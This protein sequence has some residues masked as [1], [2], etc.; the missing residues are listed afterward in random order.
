MVSCSYLKMKKIMYII[1][2]LGRNILIKYSHYCSF[3]KNNSVS[4][5][6]LNVISYLYY[7]ISPWKHKFYW[8]T[9][10]CT[11]KKMYV[12]R[13]GMEGKAGA[14]HPA[15]W[16]SKYTS[17]YLWELTAAPTTLLRCLRKQALIFPHEDALHKGDAPIKSL[18]QITS[19]ILVK[20]FIFKPVSHQ[21]VLLM[22]ILKAYSYV[23]DTGPLNEL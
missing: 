17:R 1:S 22:H 16:T 8:D 14:L 2:N 7:P 5:L 21:D 20:A 6:L 11:E 13:A 10:C 9:E 23:C 12:F 18:L 19:N 15:H 4:C 3:G